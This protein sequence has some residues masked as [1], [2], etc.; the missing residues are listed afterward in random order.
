MEGLLISELAKLAG[1]KAQTIRYYEQVGVLTPA[2]R[3]PAGYRRFG[4]RAI[5]ELT[6]VKRAQTLGFSL[7]EI[8]EIL[9]LGRSGTAPCSRVLGLARAHVSEL[10]ARIDALRRLKEQIV[11]AIGRWKDGGIPADCVSTLCGLIAGATIEEPKNPVPACDRGPL[12]PPS[13]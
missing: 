1:V 7:E 11:T 4:R 13:R 5:D 12:R 10:E 8:T 2:L 3:S 6:F 9:D